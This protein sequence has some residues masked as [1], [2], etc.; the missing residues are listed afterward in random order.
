MHHSAYKLY[1]DGYNIASKQNNMENAT[2]YE[3][4]TGS[5]ENVFLSAVTLIL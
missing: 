3:A 5:E 4:S 1:G 2:S